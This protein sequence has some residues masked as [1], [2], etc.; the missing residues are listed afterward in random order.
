MNLCSH[1][2][3]SWNGQRGVTLYQADA[4]KVLKELEPG[5]I[6][7]V[8]A[9]PPYF[10]SNGGITCHSGEMVSVD[11]GDWDR[12]RGPEADHQFSM[13]WLKLCQKVLK[14]DGTIWVSGTH[15]IIYSIGFAMQK[16]GYRLLNDIIWY[17]RNAPPNLSCR[18]FTHSTEIVLWA[19][20]SE[21]ARHTFNYDDMKR[22]N[23]GKQMRN[24]WDIL[25]PRREE[26]RFGK[27]PT[28]KPLALLE[29][30]VRASTTRGDVVLDPF[31]GS[32][33]TGVACVR[34]DREFIG[35][36]TSEDYLKLAAARIRAELDRPKQTSIAGID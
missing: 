31:C 34:H 22:E 23:G 29:R 10:L 11:K 9:D 27:H 24:V 2:F 35:I 21:D 12:S 18:Y 28:Q 20:R 26:K 3:R 16:L 7:M 4:L 5:S 36:D 19:A 25:S 32:G 8:F 17:K 13:E 15:H 1:V 30:I 6:N 14:P 33:T